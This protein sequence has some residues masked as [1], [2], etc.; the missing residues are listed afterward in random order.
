MNNQKNMDIISIVQNRYRRE[1][2]IS[3]AAPIEDVC[4]TFEALSKTGAYVQ[5]STF[6]LH[7]WKFDVRCDGKIV[8]LDGPPTSSNSVKSVTKITLEKQLNGYGT[9]LNLSTQVPKK[10]I[11]NW[12]IR[13]FIFFVGA[14]YFTSSSGLA[15]LGIPILCTV[16]SFVI[17]QSTLAS[18]DRMINFLVRYLQ[19][20]RVW[21]GLGSQKPTVK[22]LWI[23]R[24]QK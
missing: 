19:E 2:T 12:I 5:Y 22:N 16:F 13:I 9:T 10:E 6:Y 18:F 4:K 1:Y 7:Y 15:L 17:Y 21:N 24:E 8:E 14:L 20:D 3:V 11:I 23:G